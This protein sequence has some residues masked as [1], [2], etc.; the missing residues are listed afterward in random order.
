MQDT[1][2]GPGRSG[3]QFTGYSRLELDGGLVGGSGGLVGGSGG[4]KFISK[5]IQR[6]ENKVEIMHES[7]LLCNAAL[8]Q[9]YQ[10]EY[11]KHWAESN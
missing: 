1:D 10:A 9:R 4:L 2:G 3:W 8:S 7:D 6:D 11:K 5:T